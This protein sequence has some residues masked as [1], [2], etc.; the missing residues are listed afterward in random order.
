MVG[1]RQHTGVA[2]EHRLV[3]P[4]QGGVIGLLA[5]GRT[6]Q[7]RR[8]SSGGGSEGFVSSRGQLGREQE[9]VLVVDVVTDAEWGK[10]VLLGGGEGGGLQEKVRD[11]GLFC[12]GRNIFIVI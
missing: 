8:G 9:L 3:Q 12:F 7:F 6:D 5:A 1:V 11:G 4:Q 2:L 10:Y